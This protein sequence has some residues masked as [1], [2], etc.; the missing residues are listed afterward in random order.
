MNKAN[1]QHLKFYSRADVA[2]IFDV[3]M[4]TLHRL[5]RNGSIHYSKIRSRTVFSQKHVRDFIE[6][7]D[8]SG[9]K[10]AG[11]PKEKA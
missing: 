2:T 8:C 9:K 6:N 11:V 7:M 10:L 3:S 5:M 1:D 4:P